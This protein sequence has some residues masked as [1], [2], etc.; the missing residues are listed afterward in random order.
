[1]D[2]EAIAL[3]SY[4]YVSLFG[5]N[6][7]DRLKESIFENKV[8][9]EHVG[10]DPSNETFK[11]NTTAIF[12]QLSRKSISQFSKLPQIKSFAS[13]FQSLSFFSVREIIVCFDDLE[14]K[15][16]QLAM[17]DVMGL[18][19]HLKEQKKCKSVLIL[20]DDSFEKTDKEKFERYNEKIIDASIL[21]ESNSSDSL[22]IAIEGDG[23]ALEYPRDISAGLG[24][25]NI[26]IIKKIERLVLRVEPLLGKFSQRVLRQAVQS[27]S[28]L[29]WS[30]YS[31]DEAPTPEFLLRKRG[32][33]FYSYRDGEKMSEEE[34][35]WNSLLDKFGFVLADE[36]DLELYKGIKRGFF[37]EDILEIHA[38]KLHRNLKRLTLKSILKKIGAFSMI[39]LRIVKP[40]L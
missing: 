17:K 36:F 33:H 34:E 21:F 16:H 30:E 24:I 26:R 4:A 19:S 38:S 23:D 2:N 20:N 27:L 39:P 11:D 25:S 5:V 13:I 6:S 37:D 10:V 31:R 22:N 8:E 28:I 9:I 7:L 40:T 14:R 3:R 32:K 15:G 18:I 12:N 1:M 35:G 29:G